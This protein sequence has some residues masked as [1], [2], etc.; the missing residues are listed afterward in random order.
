M[1]SVQIRVPPPPQQRYI[2]DILNRANGI[3]RLRRQAQEKARQLIP[4]LFVKMFG[5]LA[6]NS[7]KC[8][9]TRFCDLLVRPLRNGISPSR[10]GRHQA[11]VLTLSAITRGYFD[12]TAI[13]VG[14]FEEPLRLGD[15]V[16]S[17]DFLICRGNGNL[18]LVGRGQFPNCSMQDVAFP[19]TIIASRPDTTRLIPEYLQ[20]VWNTDFLRRQIETAAKTTNG[21]FKINQSSTENFQLP[22]PPIGLQR[23]FATHVGNIHSIIAQQNRMAAASERLVGSL[24]HRMF[25]GA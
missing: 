16:S 21:T 10:R 7:H 6:S 3:L 17:E 22:L 5:D 13:K 24:M 23:T 15:Q 9:I 8:E 4:A 14:L 25:D 2:V 1:K 12:A 19:D 20:A 18:G 11:H